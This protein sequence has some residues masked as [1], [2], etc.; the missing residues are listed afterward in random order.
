MNNFY[1]TRRALLDI[2]TIY[3][4]SLKT[5][6]EKQAGEYTGALYSN[7]NKISNKPELGNLRKKRSTPFLMFPSG[8]HYIIYELFKD[9]I[10]II[11]VI[12]QVRNIENIVT[13][14]GSVFYKEIED[15][16]AGLEE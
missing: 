8:N 3:E 5:W 14:F 13:E 2:K 15:L 1:L 9:G 10:I 4:Y 12:H 6:G 16:K 7:F 11:T